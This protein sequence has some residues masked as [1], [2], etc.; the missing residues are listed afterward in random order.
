MPYY[1]T[2][3]LSVIIPAYN[4]ATRILPYLASI[5]TYLTRRGDSHEILVIDDGS[6]DDTARCVEKLSVTERAIRLV[7]LSRNTGKGAAVRTG[8]MTARGDLHL[9]A[10][11]DGATPIDEVERL[12]TRIRRGADIAVGSRS[13]ASHDSRFAV[14]ARWHR[15]I[16]GNVFNRIV[17]RMGIK[18]ITDTQCGF[19]LL[20]RT[21][22]RDLSS[23]ARI[24]GY[25]FDL[26]LL[27]VAQRRG[28]H[29]DE[30]P[31][32]WIDQPGSKVRIVRDGFHTLCELLAVRRND[33][34][35]RYTSIRLHTATND[36]R[37]RASQS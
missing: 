31:I 26:E 19:K 22:A 13:L 23:V 21:V 6:Q 25:G 4:E 17:K 11:A 14:R 33:L 8:M 28:Y 3:Q 9:L 7:Q 5:T 27:Y 12:E 34:L 32:N 24:N 16:L 36:F 1:C 2:P 20:R 37:E 10:D 35:G 15:A 29:I 30:V 18:K